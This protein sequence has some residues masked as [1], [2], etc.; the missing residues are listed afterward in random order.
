MSTLGK[1]APV[2]RRAIVARINRRLAGERCMIRCPRLGSAEASTFGDYYIYDWV[3]N[4]VIAPRINLRD[5]AREVGAMADYEHIDD[6][7]G[8]K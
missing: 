2:S 7:K 6:A 1:T 4:R 3:R 5:Y 8:R